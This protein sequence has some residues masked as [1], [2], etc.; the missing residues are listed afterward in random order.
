MASSKKEPWPGHLAKPIRKFRP[1]GFRYPGEL[2]RGYRYL[3]DWDSWNNLTL[4]A[5]ASKKVSGNEPIQAKDLY[6]SPLFKMAR[7]YAEYDDQAWFILSAKYGLLHPD[8]VVTPYN[9]ALTDMKR[10]EQMEWGKAVREQMRKTFFTGKEY[11]GPITVLA[12]ASYR[13]ELVPFLESM[14][15]DGTVSVPMEGLGIGQ[16]LRWLKR[17][18]A[19]RGLFDLDG[20]LGL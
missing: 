13:Q 16:Q 2:G 12:G 10:A 11:T 20:E 15:R 18:N 8:S 14:V 19:T 5:C 4:V 9:M 3:G 1:R 6:T 17:A 7:E